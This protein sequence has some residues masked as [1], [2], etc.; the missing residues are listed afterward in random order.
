MLRIN[1]GM[2][3]VNHY[4]TGIG[5]FTNRM[6]LELMKYSDLDCSGNIFYTPGL[7]KS[8][9]TRFDFPVKMSWLPAR[10]A[11]DTRLRRLPVSM[12]RICRRQSDI[13]LFFNYK[14][15][16]VKLDGKVITTIHDLIPLKTEMENP[17]VKKRYLA[18]VQD[19]V[20]HSDRIL[21]V[22]EHSKSDLLSY[23]AIPESKL[24]VVPNGVDFA[25]F[26]APVRPEEREAVRKRYQLPEKFILY[27]GSTRKHKNVV[28]ILKAYIRLPESIRNTYHLVITNANEQLRQ[29]AAE[30]GMQ[31]F[32]R[33]VGRVDAS[34]KV[35]FYQLADLNLFLSLYEGFGIPVIEAMAAGVP[36]IASDT[37][38]LPEVA[39]DAAILVDPLAVGRITQAMA[40]VLTDSGLRRDMIQRGQVNAQKYSW[41]NAAKKLHDWLISEFAAKP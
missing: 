27:F 30:A 9:L 8:D 39:A 12:S 5:V 38:S 13:N 19:A 25:D 31:P 16:R 37:S 6:I 2:Q 28:S 40:D 36:V 24:F 33:F 20:E 18:Q 35:A 32:I 10:F 3:E 34:D 1:F 21:T 22:S 17:S 4:S 14:L 41:E 15:P 26:N 11:Y 7:S 23:F 29:M